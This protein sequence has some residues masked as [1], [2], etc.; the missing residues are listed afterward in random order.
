[1][2]VRLIGESAGIVWRQL[3]GDNRKWEFNELADATGLSKTDLSAAI[4]WL[5]REGKIQIEENADKGKDI[6]YLALNYYIG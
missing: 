1:M 6:F 3:N 5:A 2:N 4:G